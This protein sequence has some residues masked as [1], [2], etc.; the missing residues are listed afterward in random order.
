MEHVN[1]PKHYNQHP[2][3]IECIDVIRHYIC[4]IANAIKYLWR[5]G[6]KQEMGME[7]EE[8][9]KEDV[10]KA[11][12]Y[13]EDLRAHYHDY[14]C[15]EMPFDAISELVQTEVGYTAE[16]IT[17]GYDRRVARAMGCLLNIGLVHR[18]AVYSFEFAIADLMDVQMNLKQYIRDV[19]LKHK[20]TFADLLGCRNARRIWNCLRAHDIHTIEDLA[21]LTQR[22]V[23]HWRNF[24]RVCYLEVCKMMKKYG[25]EF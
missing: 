25:V 24:G 10:E 11:I 3:G 18:N 5:A 8:K 1:H 7:D 16:Q 6:L 9:E 20:I 19:M 22:D 21:K 12:W 4:D 13:I 14:R 23:L 17:E 15:N 2:A